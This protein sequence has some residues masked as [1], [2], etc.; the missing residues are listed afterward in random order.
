[1]YSD[2]GSPTLTSCTLSGNSADYLGGGLF[3]DNGTPRLITCLVSG[4]SAGNSG[5]GI[6]VASGGVTLTNCTF[7]ANRGGIE[8]GGMRSA[9]DEPAALTSCIFW[10]NTDAGRDDFLA[11]VNVASAAAL[12]MNYCCIQGWTDDWEGDGN[13]GADPQFADPDG[14]DDIPGTDDDE[15]HLTPVSPCINAGDPDAVLP[16]VL[17]I[18]GEDR[19]QHCRVDIGADETPFF[20]DCD[21]NDTPDACDIRS[22]TA[23]DCNL[24]TVLDSCEVLSTTTLLV[25]S[26]RADS[27][28]A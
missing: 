19:I 20:R 7:A 9:S 2:G 12:F 8:G 11:Q 28:I 16:A 18:D 23:L 15:L 27:V 21:G 1:V 14:P 4:N 13:S 3:I 26:G 6:M 17:D 22:E 24:N 5:G 10:G 25:T